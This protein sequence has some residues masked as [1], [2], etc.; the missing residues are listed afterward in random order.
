MTQ[1]QQEDG[2][3]DTDNL[4]KGYNMQQQCQKEA[5]LV[6]GRGKKGF[7]VAFSPRI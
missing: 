1:S 6:W 2:V 5:Y 3:T 7:S 4:D